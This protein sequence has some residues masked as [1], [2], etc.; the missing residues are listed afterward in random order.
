MAINFSDDNAKVTVKQLN[1][2][3]QGMAEKN[4]ER[5]AV[6]GSGGIDIVIGSTAPSGDNTIWLRPVT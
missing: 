3:I 2:V 1:D 4:D 5:Y 6:A